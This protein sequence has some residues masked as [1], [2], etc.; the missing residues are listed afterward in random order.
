[1][2]LSWHDHAEDLPADLWADTFRPPLEGLWWYLALERS[3]LDDQF[4][5]LY[6]QLADDAGQPLGIA[7]CFLMDVPL[8]MFVPEPLQP[9]VRPLGRVYP[10][11]LH[12]RTLFVGSPCSD[13]GWVGL[14]S[15]IDRDAALRALQHGIAAKARELR[16]PMRVWKDF[17]SVFDH[18]MASV[19]ARA[20]LF[21][22]VSFPGTEI[23]LPSP[24]K[25]DYLRALPGS[26]GERLRRNVKRSQREV[27][28]DVRVEPHPDAAM[29]DQVFGLFMQT[30]ERATTRF[31]RLSRGFFDQMAQSPASR[32]I[33]LQH[34]EDRR[35]VAFM[36]CFDLGDTLVNKFIGL[37]YERPRDWRLYFR[38]WDQFIDLALALDKKRVESGQ[39]GYSG[40]FVTGH[41]LLPLTNWCQ[42]ANPVLAWIY[43]QVGS[44]VSWASL[45]PEL[46]DAAMPA[47]GRALTA[48]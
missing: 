43:R 1:M 21:R 5:F 46:A 48:P 8:E 11:L 15:G 6:A 34:A 47:P 42:H 32:F 16:A 38:L 27:R 3:G 35:L 31:E 19:A 14:R 23:A 13:R 24:A 20:G 9:I 36:L 30:Y 41:S 45:D 4:R 18:E 12:Q 28:L 22:V 33:L 25:S 26:G 10:P 44:R 7:P 37:D 2:K 29:L 40:K 17:P 39:T